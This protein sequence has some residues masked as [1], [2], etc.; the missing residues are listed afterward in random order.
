MVHWPSTAS[1]RPMQRTTHHASR[2]SGRR[3]WPVATTH[4]DCGEAGL[5]FTRGPLIGTP[6]EPRRPRGLQRP[7]SMSSSSAVSLDA[8]ERPQSKVH[9][10]KSTVKTHRVE[11][12]RSVSRARS[13]EQGRASNSSE[14][15]QHSPV[16]RP[17]LSTQD[18]TYPGSF[19]RLATAAKSTPRRPSCPPA[20]Q[21]PRPRSAGVHPCRR[22]RT[23][24][25]PCFQGFH[26]RIPK[27]S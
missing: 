10:Q 8:R 9:S 23:T 12:P 26:S 1:E 27:P 2:R 22:L 14:Q 24:H 21:S 20:A 7:V 18:K 19:S 6:G 17:D 4:Q 13:S 3:R 16:R 25:P 5:L 11:R 15:L